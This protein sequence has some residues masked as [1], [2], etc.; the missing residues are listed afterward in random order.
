FVVERPGQI[1]VTTASGVVQSTPFLDIR[2]QVRDNATE[3]GLLGLAFHPDYAQNGYFYVNYITGTNATKRTRISRFSRD[4][5]DSSRA[6]IS[7]ELILLEI[8]QPYNN[9]NAGD[10]NFGPDGYLYASLGDGGSGGDPDNYAQNRLSLLGKILRLDVDQGT[11][12]GIPADNPFV[13]D[14]STRDE[15]WS[16]GWRNPWRF[17]FDRGTGDMWIADVGQD[18]YEEVSFEAAGSPGGLNYGWRC[19]EGDQTYNSSGCGTVHLYTGP[20]FSYLHNSVST[21]K[22]ITGGY[23]YRGEDFPPLQGHYVLG[24]YKSGNF[25]T[26]FPDGSGG[27]GSTFQGN[28]LGVDECSTFGE[29]AEGELYVAAYG[30]GHIY[31]VTDANTALDPTQTRTALR[32]YPHPLRESATID[33]PGAGQ[34]VFSLHLYD[35]Q[36]RRL[37]HHSGLSGHAFTL[38]RA[39]LKTGLYVLEV[40]GHLGT[41]Q[42]MKLRVQ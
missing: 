27:W 13:N 26:V 9:H 10:L 25:W 16:L 35:L 42:V 5:Q 36:G 40:Q 18:Q 12:Y 1:W 6:D 39:G 30:S 24:D 11:P 17:S 28:L 7:S 14:P 22:S 21:G 29:D 8:S 32:V 19:L 37:R 15:I 31:R 4:P 20:I 23:V 34:E 3:Q 2:S 41:R 38:H 33:L